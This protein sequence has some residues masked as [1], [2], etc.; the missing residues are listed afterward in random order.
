MSLT[1]KP[2]AGGFIL[3]VADGNL[4][5]DNAVLTSGENLQAGA[6]LAKVDDEYI[7]LAP[8]VS[9]ASGV[10]VA[11]LFDAVDAS[12][13]AK[14]CVVVARVAEVNGDELVWPDGTSDP[15]KATAIADLALQHII[16]R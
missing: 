16:V 2:H 4:S 13:G 3:S 1:E 12:A 11:V 10:A 14:A 9:D 5:L 15:Q 7:A 6:V 8:G